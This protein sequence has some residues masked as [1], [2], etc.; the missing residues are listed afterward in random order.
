MISGIVKIDK[1][2]DFTSQDCDRIVKRQL[3]VKKTGHLGTLDPFATGLLIV[4][5]LD[6]N[7]IF[8]LIDD[9]Y[10]TYVATLKLG[11]ET[12]T[13][14]I[15]GKIIDK[16]EVGELSLSQI[17]STLH[18]FLGKGKQTPPLYSAKMINGIRCYHLAREGAKNVSIPEMD[19]EILDIQLLSYDEKEHVIV[20]ETTV[21]KG[22][23]IRT[24][25]KDIAHKLG[26]PG[27][28]LALRRTK[29]GP[30]DLEGAVKVKEVK[31]SDVFP[32]EDFI[33]NIKRMECD[34]TLAFRVK[35]GQ[36]LKFPQEKEEYLLLQH[37]HK[38]LAIYQRNGHIYQSYKG[39]QHEE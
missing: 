11:E 8:P 14:D 9:S 13:L 32:L 33:P 22:T 18:S 19:I 27:Y 21:S 1:E 15:E 24:L 17:E 23:Y 20:F 16:K 6:G 36:K 4:G 26:Y 28:L 2:R 25:G 7:K 38:N 31:E 10:K 39:F 29:I 35:N 30:F 37:N 34:D 5:V 12:N 3:Q